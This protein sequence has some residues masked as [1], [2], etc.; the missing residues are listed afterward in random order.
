MMMTVESEELNLDYKIFFCVCV[1]Y[2]QPFYRLENFP[3]TYNPALSDDSELYK[4]LCQ[5]L[6]TPFTLHLTHNLTSMVKTGSEDAVKGK[7]M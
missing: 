1:L 2:I 6:A 3:S 7:R 4:K 5:S